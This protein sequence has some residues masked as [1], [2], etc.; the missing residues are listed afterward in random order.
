M[1]KLSEEE[2][3]DAI[4]LNVILN[5]VEATKNN[6]DYNYWNEALNWAKSDI[7]FSDKTD[8]EILSIFRK[9]ETW[10]DF[11]EECIQLGHKLQEG[12]N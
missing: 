12:A 6:T 1:N 9:Y 5:G 11:E 2:K 8:E 4:L 7:T 10:N 3:V